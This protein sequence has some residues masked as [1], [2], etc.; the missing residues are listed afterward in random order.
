[1]WKALPV[2]GSA[3]AGIRAQVVD[4]IAGRLVDDAENPEAIA[5]TLDAM[6][7]DHKEREVWGRNA[8]DRVS[9]K[10]LIFSEVR[11]WLQL[12]AEV[13]PAS[14]AGGMDAVLNR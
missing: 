9:R 4:G 5:K 8:R 3:A 2:M 10:F 13:A 12:L 1:M 7:M 11:R 14:N 6:F